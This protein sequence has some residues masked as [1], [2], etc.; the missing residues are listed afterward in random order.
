MRSASSLIEEKTKSGA[1]SV[2]GIPEPLVRYTVL[3]PALYPADTSNQWSP[4]I[5]VSRGYAP[6]RR[7]ASQTPCGLGLG[8][9]ASSRQRITWKSAS[10]TQEKFFRARRTESLLFLVIIPNG[11]ACSF[12]NSSSSSA[13]GLGSESAAARSSY[14]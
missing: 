1:G 5:S 9:K 12:R 7:T 4:I 6:N 14:R 3:T 13:P 11:I 10:S 2:G 8:S